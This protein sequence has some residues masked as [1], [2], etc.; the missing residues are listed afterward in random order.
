MVAWKGST[1]RGWDASQGCPRRAIVSQL[2]APT[3]FE[4]RSTQK[5]ESRITGISKRHV[6]TALR[7]RAAR[8]SSA[9]FPRAYSRTHFSSLTTVLPFCFTSEALPRM[10]YR[11][12]LTILA[13]L[14]CAIQSHQR[15][16][17]ANGAVTSEV[18]VCSKVGV[19][20]LRDGGNAADAVSYLYRRNIAV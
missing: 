14:S 17:G 3:T 12:C 18:E 8:C 15:S 1:A 7:T 6:N 5:A 10:A 4:Q 16:I 2:T 9:R 11:F 13:I 19:N 20:L